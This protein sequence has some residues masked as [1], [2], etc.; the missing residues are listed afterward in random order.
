MPTS[1]DASLPIASGACGS[2]DDGDLLGGLRWSA[3]GL[4]VVGFSKETGVEAIGT[5][6]LINLCGAGVR[7]LH[8]FGSQLRP[9]AGSLDS[10]AYSRA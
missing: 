9:P 7:A 10:S 5:S 8:R 6:D 1:R 3:F 2:V 4:I